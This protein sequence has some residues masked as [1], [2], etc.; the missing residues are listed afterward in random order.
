MKLYFF[1]TSALVKHYHP[2]IGHKVVQTLFAQS[3]AKIVIS[4]LTIVE[5]HSAMYK[6]VR[7]GELKLSEAKS[8]L[9]FMSQEIVS[10]KL[11]VTHLEI[12]H[13]RDA[14]S[15]LSKYAPKHFLRT[16]DALQLAVALSL[17]RRNPLEAFVTADEDLARVAEIDGLPVLNPAKSEAQGAS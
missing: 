11:N 1:D 14:A 7:T 9:G 10:G 15:L 17:H 2:E 12:E 6:K 4:T 8:V 16:L 13:Y 5:M 3:D